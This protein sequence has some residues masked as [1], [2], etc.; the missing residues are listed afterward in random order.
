M[1]ALSPI[2]LSFST[3]SLVP[4]P[5]VL[6]PSPASRLPSHCTHPNVVD[7]VSQPLG[8]SLSRTQPVSARDHLKK[9]FS[10]PLPLPTL[11]S[12]PLPLS[13]LASLG[14]PSLVLSLSSL[15]LT[16][17]PSPQPLM[18]TSDAG[19]SECQ[20]TSGTLKNHTI[21]PDLSNIFKPNSLYRVKKFKSRRF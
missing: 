7:Y 6:N 4:S 3:P 21:S 19:F 17:Q 16:W 14:T 2:G 18:D 5:C 9:P 11:A 15:F 10:L 12:P 1:T 13:T 8:S 20:P